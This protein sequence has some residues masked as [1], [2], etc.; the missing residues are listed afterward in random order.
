MSAWSCWCGL[1]DLIR[2]E[3]STRRLLMQAAERGTRY[4]TEIANRRFAPLA[5]DVAGL[6]ALVGPL[7]QSPSDPATGAIARA[8]SSPI[9]LM[10]TSIPK[11]QFSSMPFIAASMSCSFKALM[12]VLC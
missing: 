2:P 1:G 3:A 6:E 12:I 8:Y 4:V 7:S 10:S 11:R 5:A 9:F